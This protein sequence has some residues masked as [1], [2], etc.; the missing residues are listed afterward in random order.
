MAMLGDFL[1][2][3]KDVSIVVADG[4]LTHAATSVPKRIEESHC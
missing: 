4:E 2:K 3:L 1:A